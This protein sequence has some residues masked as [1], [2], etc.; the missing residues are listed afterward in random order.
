MD[1]MV[2]LPTGF[3]SRAALAV[4]ALALTVACLTA[5]GAAFAAG[6]GAA[7][8]GDEPVAVAD[9]AISGTVSGPGGVPLVAGTT[10]CLAVFSS[11]DEYLGAASF[12]DDGVYTVTGLATGDYNLGFQTSA[13]YLLSW[14]KDATS[15]STATP[16]HVVQGA[17]TGDISPQLLDG[18][19]CGW[20][21]VGEVG[22]PF[23][24][25]TPRVGYGPR[26]CAF[27]RP[28]SPHRAARLVGPGLL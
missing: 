15:L 4:L 13:M 14:W 2:T 24:A 26:G 19:G 18:M 16:V 25:G 7:D 10:G 21:F 5:P 22:P 12:S 20:F 9:G 3:V 28:P 17:T 8:C 11:S 1:A 23:G 27:L 6:S